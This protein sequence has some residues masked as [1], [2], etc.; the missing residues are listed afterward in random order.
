M[1][2]PEKKTNPGKF[3][4]LTLRLD[5]VAQSYRAMAERREIKTLLPRNGT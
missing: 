4:D 2:A 5:Q 1:T 3:F